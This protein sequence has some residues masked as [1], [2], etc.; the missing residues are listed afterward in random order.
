MAFHYT[1]HKSS[2]CTGA[3]TKNVLDHEKQL[4]SCINI[5]LFIQAISGSRM[6]KLTGD[7]SGM[8]FF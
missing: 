2:L 4:L 6:S 5:I 7:V 8:P 3:R 1:D